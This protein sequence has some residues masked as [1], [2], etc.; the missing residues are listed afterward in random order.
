MSEW[1]IKDVN[2]KQDFSFELPVGS[3]AV[4]K[5][6]AFEIE[7]SDEK[8]HTYN[9]TIQDEDDNII[10]SFET[11]KNEFTYTFDKT[12]NYTVV[13]TDKEGVIT[14]FTINLSVVSPMDVVPKPPVTPI[15]PTPTI[16]K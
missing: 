5:E 16:T 3:V 4:D 2:Y 1:Y 15:F 9:V 14:P 12:G 8:V 7:P 13:I 6:V 10:A 11:S